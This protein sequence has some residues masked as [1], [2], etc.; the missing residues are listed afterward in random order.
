M[1][2]SKGAKDKGPRKQRSETAGKK[3]ASGNA[4]QM[5]A[6]L[7]AKVIFL[8]TLNAAGAAGSNADADN[9]R[10]EGADG[11]IVADVVG[12]AAA[13]A[14]GASPDVQPDVCNDASPDGAGADCAS[15]PADGPVPPPADGAAPPPAVGAAPLPA[16]GTA[17]PPPG[18]GGPLPPTVWQPAASPVPPMAELDDDEQ[19]E[20]EV[21]VMAVYLK[22]LHDRLKEEV[23]NANLN[24]P[25]R[26]AVK[27]WLLP[28]LKGEAVNWTLSSAM[29]P[30]V[31]KNLGIH[32]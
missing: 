4:Q 17:P 5:A 7:A 30:K 19:L 28:L 22:A 14:A 8:R 27:P 32:S 24:G 15:P 13:D 21:D 26:T 2:R 1:G 6:N 25:K 29:A 3:A 16:D 18:D 11:G 23:G 12:G 9:V 31:C 10:S 20:D